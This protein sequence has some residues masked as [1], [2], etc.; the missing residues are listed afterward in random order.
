M[1]HLNKMVV[2]TLISA[3]IVGTAIFTYADNKEHRENEAIAMNEAPVKMNQALEI[4]LAVM[5]G[6]PKEVEFEVE[7]GKSIWEVEVVNADRDVYELEID[8][9]S[10][11]VLKQELEDDDH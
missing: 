7:G 6:T 5:P 3:G 10:G 8:A 4:A 1:K 2:A 11:E 9:T